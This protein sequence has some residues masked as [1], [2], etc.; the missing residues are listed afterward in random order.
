ML[1]QHLITLCHVVE[2]HSFTHAADSLHVSQPTVTKQ[3]QALED[4]IGQPLVVRDGRPPHLTPAGEV[5]Y[6]HARR[7]LNLV[8]DCHSAIREI[9]APGA[10][11]LAI[12]AVPSL[13][14]TTL[15]QP[16][17]EYTRTHKLVAVHVS[18]GTNAEVTSMVLRNE[19]DAG[20]TT[21]PVSHPEIVDFP[22][23]ADEIF[24]VASAQGR[25]S[26]NSPLSSLDLSKLPMISYKQKSH[27]RAFVDSAFHTA[28]ITPNI[29]MEFDSHEAVK[30]MVQLDLGVAMLPASAVSADIAAGRLTPMAIA[31]FST[32]SRVTTLITRRDKRITPAMTDFISV[33]RQHFPDPP[34]SFVKKELKGGIQQK[35]SE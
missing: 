20:L 19:I 24:L 3:I 31:G 5:V 17:S 18:T 25:Y 2:E 10:G 9:S 27:F 14:L 12:G 22:L 15:P 34:L 35:Q 6:S 28:G 11:D 1:L 26:R 8:K 30:T 23:C 4:E 16:L 21:I 33:M 29:V 13:A 7:I 32:L